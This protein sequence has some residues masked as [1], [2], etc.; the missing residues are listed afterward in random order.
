[1]LQSYDFRDD[2]FFNV[3]SEDEIEL[4]AQIY[5]CLI[6][7]L[8]STFSFMTL[9]DVKNLSVLFHTESIFLKFG[10]TLTNF[11]YLVLNP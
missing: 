9:Y 1:M 7:D 8:E 2:L 11:P 4:A 6:Y 5:C 3:L 10:P